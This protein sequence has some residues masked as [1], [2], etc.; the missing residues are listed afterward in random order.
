VA[1]VVREYLRRFP[2][3]CQRR[4]DGVSVYYRHSKAS[5]PQIEIFRNSSLSA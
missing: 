2:P 4:F 1:A 3:S 5:R